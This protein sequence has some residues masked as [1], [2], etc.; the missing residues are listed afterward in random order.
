MTVTRRQKEDFAGISTAPTPEPVTT[1][2][3]NII[4]W[5]KEPFERYF[6]DRDFRF[7]PMNLGER[8]FERVWKPRILAEGNADILA[9]GPELPGPLD[10]LAKA[11]NIPV[12]FIEDGFLRSVRPSASRT[13]PLSLALDGKALHFDCRKPS[14]LEAL[15]KT[16]DFEADAALMGRARAGIA[17]LIESGISKY[18][19]TRRRTAEE[20]YGDK[21]R[22][23]VLVV[24]QV[25]DDASVRYGC[26]APMTNNDLVRLAASEQADA[27]ILYKPHPDVLSRARP[28]RSDPAEVAHL[29]ELVTESLPLAEALRTVDHVYTITSLAGFEAL[30]RGIPVTTAGC[31]FYSGWG[32][33]D[34]RQPN[35]R[36]GRHLS[37]EA[38]FAGAYLL[39]PRYFDPETGAQ[40]SFE[41]TVAA[42][43]RQ[44][45]EPQAPRPPRP[46]WC[47]W[48]PYGLFGWRH[49]LTVFLTPVI[50][51]I[52]SDRDVEDFRADP[53][54]FFRS[55][56][57]RKYRIIGR[58]LYPFG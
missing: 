47:A 58:I 13:P 57:E 6:P 9:W 4:G 27:Q 43:R 34:D 2:A 37:I 46:Q 36:R 19:G 33:T 51:R 3:V 42:I 45:D 21:T 5:K 31:P 15:L 49:L 26:V 18:N 53:I 1:F 12:T 29:C 28:A 17:L 41:A 7:L 50:R 11:R 56:S 25:E 16:Y 52:G 54:R 39:Y 22:K 35:P 48:G 40:T 20:V 38:L 8:E 30:I 55:L 10:A 32:L 23:R 24:G 14:D 44:L